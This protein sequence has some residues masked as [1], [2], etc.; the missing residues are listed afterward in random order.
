MRHGYRENWPAWMYRVCL[1]YLDE[2]WSR[3]SVE[4]ESGYNMT[5]N[6]LPVKVD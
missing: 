3:K 5:G 6:P 2:E 4:Y 1:V